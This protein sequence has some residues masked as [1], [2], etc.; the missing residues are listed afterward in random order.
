[1]F[2]VLYFAV[3]CSLVRKSIFVSLQILLD[4]DGDD[5]IDESDYLD[6]E[7]CSAYVLL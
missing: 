2:Y 4:P 5:S 6:D 7:V 3:L 1:M